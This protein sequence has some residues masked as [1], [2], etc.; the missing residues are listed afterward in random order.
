MKDTCKLLD[1]PLILSVSVLLTG[2][3]SSS[4]LISPVNRPDN[5]RILGIGGVVISNG[6]DSQ[7]LLFEH[8]CMQGWPRDLFWRDRD[9]IR[10]PHCRDQ[11]VQRQ[12]LDKTET[13]RLFI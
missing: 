8:S 12:L 2:A 7:K 11:D 6:H 4:S 1:F 9:E 13:E 5:V 10:D 3:S